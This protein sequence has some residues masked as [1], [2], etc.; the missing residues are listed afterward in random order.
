[1]IIGKRLRDK[2]IP[3]AHMVKGIAHPHRVAIIYLLLHD[4]LWI[5]DIVNYLGIPQNLVSHHMK[6][7]MASGWVKKKREGKHVEYSINEKA[8]RALS[9]M[10]KETPLWKKKSGRL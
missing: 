1:M 2:V 9:D 3:Y 4:P 10:F 7:M 8:F 5:K 6:Q